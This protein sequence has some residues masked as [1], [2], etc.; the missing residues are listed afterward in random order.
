MVGQEVEG[1]GRGVGVRYGVQGRGDIV[2]T[3]HVQHVS[4]IGTPILA[5]RE[6]G[7]IVTPYE[8]G[9]IVAVANAMVMYDRT[10]AVHTWRDLAAV[11]VA[12]AEAYDRGAAVSQ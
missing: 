10:V 12:A 8:E 1:A 2:E 7:G 5:C 4:P 3:H 6:R 9:K 11:A